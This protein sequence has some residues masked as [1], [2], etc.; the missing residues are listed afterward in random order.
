MF[1]VFFCMK[2]GIS[3]VPKALCFTYFKQGV[4]NKVQSLDDSRYDKLLSEFFLRISAFKNFLQ[5]KCLKLNFACT[6]YSQ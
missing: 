1:P 2:T 4:D 3:P 6:I 5:K